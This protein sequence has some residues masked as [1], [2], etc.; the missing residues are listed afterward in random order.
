MYMIIYE[1]DDDDDDDEDEDDSW[2]CHW[3]NHDLSIS[4]AVGGIPIFA[5]APITP[6]L[7]Q[8]VAA[9]RAQ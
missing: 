1:Y 3:L 4:I 2:T 7:V 9:S 5:A 8:R 6:I